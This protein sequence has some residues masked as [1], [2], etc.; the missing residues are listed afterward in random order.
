MRHCGYRV[1]ALLLLMAEAVNLHP[2]DVL[3]LGGA[4]FP[5][6]TGQGLT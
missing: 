6:V 3:V 4:T 5:W 1:S 2:G